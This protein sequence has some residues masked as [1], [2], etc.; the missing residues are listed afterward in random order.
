MHA[1]R[2]WVERIDPMSDSITFDIFRDTTAKEWMNRYCKNPATGV[3]S[4][5]RCGLIFQEIAYYAEVD[6]DQSITIHRGKDGPLLATG[7]PRRNYRH[8]LLGASGLGSTATCSP[9]PSIF[10]RHH[11]FRLSWDKLS[12][13]RQYCSD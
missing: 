13:E 7:T 12:L 3:S 5:L 4:L 10:P 6:D 1:R 2:G 8:S 9:S 11:F